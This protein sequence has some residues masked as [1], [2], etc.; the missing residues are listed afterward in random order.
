MEISVLTN[1]RIIDCTGADPL[2]DIN[3]FKEYKKNILLIIQSGRTYK[4]I[5]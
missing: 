2:K 5:L 3:V 4:N 1:A